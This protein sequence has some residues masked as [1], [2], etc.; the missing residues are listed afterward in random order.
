MKE[1]LSSLKRRLGK[2]RNTT[3]RVAAII[4]LSLV[5]AGSAF[6]DSF[7]LGSALNYAVLVEANLHNF[8]LSSDSGITG[9]VGIGSPINAVQ[10]ASGTINGNLDFSGAS[11]SGGPNFGGTVTGSVNTNFSDVT[12]ALSNANAANTTLGAEAGTALTISGNTTVNA[13]S[14]TLDGAG[15]R[16]F[17]VTSGNF[18]IGNGHT[19]TINGTAGQTVV[20]NID[21]GT[22]NESINGA[23]TLTGGITANHVLFNFVGTGGQ[24]GGA[25]ND[26]VANGI[27]L[28][29]DMKV[30]LNSVTIDGEIIGGGSSTSNNDFQIVSNAFVNGPVSVPEPGTLPMLAMGLLG[31]AAVGFARRRFN[32]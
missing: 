24:L 31:L 4:A 2:M 14:G 6:A 28:A 19:L 20:I 32:S 7:G 9:N 15:N 21:N 8:Q 16:V 23:I 29:P 27:F 17:T 13:I 1:P 30:N 5:G 3:L 12:T 25:A 26:A 11:P 18:N 22:T 10:L